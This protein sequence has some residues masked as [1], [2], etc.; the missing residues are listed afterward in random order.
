MST[1]DNTD[2]VATHLTSRKTQSMKHACVN[3]LVRHCDA[4]PT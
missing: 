3:I 1:V 2:L 4:D